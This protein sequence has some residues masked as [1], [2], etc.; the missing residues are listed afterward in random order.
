MNKH[1]KDQIDQ[2]IETKKEGNQSKEDIFLGNNI[3]RE[4]DELSKSVESDFDDKM[5]PLW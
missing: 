3:E 4:T 5:Y 2:N 1:D